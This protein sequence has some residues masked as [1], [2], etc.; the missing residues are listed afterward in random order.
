[1][2]LFFGLQLAIFSILLL[3]LAFYCTSMPE[4]TYIGALPPLSEVE[5]MI[6]D[7]VRRHVHE[8]AGQIGERNL[9]H[10]RALTAAAD[11]IRS[12][13]QQSGYVVGQQS[14][15]VEGKKATNL[16]VELPGESLPDQIVIIG[17]HYDSVA[18]SPGANDNGSGVAALIELARILKQSELVK[19]V[20]FVAFTNEEPPYFQTDKMGSVVY[21]KRCFEQ[22]DK[23][24]AMLSLET[25]GYYSDASGSQTY[26]FPM[27]MFYPDKGNF[28]GFVGNTS[29]RRVVRKCVQAFRS[30]AKF[31]CE[32]V[33]AP[34]WVMGIGWSDQWSFWQKG[35]PAVM[36]T[37]TAPFRYPHYHTRSDTPD[38]LDYDRLAR[39][40]A[41]LA[42]V[43]KSVASKD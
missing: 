20:R 6:R 37:D 14:Y 22:R 29:S 36:V 2:W 9:D 15:D 1:M 27:N 5:L 19:T 30:N 7:G 26:P 42:E 41:G 35:Y 38:K 23:I 25:I 33:A 18:G 10:P 21:A 17:A 13:L 34:G 24:V 4:N 12:E 43:V 32:G 39:V 3:S 16:E 8:I 40:V 31:P 11:Y 28:I